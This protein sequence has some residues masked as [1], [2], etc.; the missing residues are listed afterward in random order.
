MVVVFKTG[1][2]IP[3]NHEIASPPILTVSA[4]RSS[5][6]PLLPSTGMSMTAKRPKYRDRG[7]ERHRGVGYLRA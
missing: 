1:S 6:P 2:L 5:E 4:I 7:D 3:A